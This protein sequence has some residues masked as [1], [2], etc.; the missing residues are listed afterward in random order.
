MNEDHNKYIYAAN[1]HLHDV[2]TK[3]I[4]YLLNICSQLHM[5]LDFTDRTE[6]DISENI[7]MYK[8]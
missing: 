8:Q 7:S 2:I 4:S 3:Y 1:A 5:H 6:T